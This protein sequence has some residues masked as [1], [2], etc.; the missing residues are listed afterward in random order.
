MGHETMLSDCMIHMGHDLD[1]KGFVRLEARLRKEP[2]VVAAGRSPHQRDLM[3][4]AFDPNRSSL[5]AIVAA[6]SESGVKAVGITL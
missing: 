5:K 2:G 6:A 3:M 4:V 1:D